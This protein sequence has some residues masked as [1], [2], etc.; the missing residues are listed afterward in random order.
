VSL[1]RAVVAPSELAGSWTLDPP[2]VAMLVLAALAYCRGRARLGRRIPSAARAGR[3]VAF[4]AGLLVV[5]GALMSPLDALSAALFS[6]HMVQHLLLMVVAAPLLV[7]ARP[8]AALV[9]GLPPVARQAARAL[10]GDFWRGAAR[11]AVNPVVVWTVGALAVWAWH[12]PTLY[13]A[14]LRH[15][16]LHAAEHA[17]FLGAAMLFWAVVLRSGGPRRLPRPVAALLVLATGVQSSALG[18]VLLFASNPLYPAHRVGA[19]VWKVSPLGDQ[20]LAGALMWGPPWLLYVAVMWWLLFRWFEDMD[21]AWPA[22][23]TAAAN[24]VWPEPTG[25]RRP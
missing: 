15:D 4:Y 12:M 9:A 21:D 18:A 2:V 8:G 13:D 17:S 14:A 10:R 25:A 5:G 23:F 16:A 1:G 6:A 24:P 19:L 7:Y 11:V 3:D 22:T 20:Q